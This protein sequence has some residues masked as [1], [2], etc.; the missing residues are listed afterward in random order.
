MARAA[1]L[2]EYRVREGQGAAAV[3]AI[4]MDQR[5]PSQPNQRE[6][7]KADGQDRTQAPERVRALEVVHV[8]ALREFFC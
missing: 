5:I 3:D 4:V 6:Q 1:L 7:R 2:R 8:D